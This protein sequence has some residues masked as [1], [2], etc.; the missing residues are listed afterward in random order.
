MPRPWFVQQ[1]PWN[2]RQEAY[3]RIVRGFNSAVG[4]QDR[5]R[6]LAGGRKRTCACASATCCTEIL[7][8]FS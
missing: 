2:Y 7:K 8:R 3:V 5:P 4:G 6:Q 1:P